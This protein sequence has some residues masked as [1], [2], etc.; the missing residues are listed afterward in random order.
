MVGA[1]FGWRPGTARAIDLG[2]RLT[3]HRLQI[4]GY[5]GL[6]AVSLG[7]GWQAE[8]SPTLRAGFSAD[9]VNGARWA[10][11]ERL[12]RRLSAGLAYRP[13]PSAAVFAALRKE[14]WR[15]GSSHVGVDWHPVP[16]LSVR[17]GVA[18]APRRAAGGFALA[19]RGLRVEAAVERHF[20]LGWTPA[21]AVSLLA[22]SAL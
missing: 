12:P 9:N 21:L 5:E 22:G 15:E 10:R 1:G 7:A 6:A 17:V 18:T 19:W 16:A 2:V 4:A 13:T 11:G 3:Y 20:A 8:L 14:T